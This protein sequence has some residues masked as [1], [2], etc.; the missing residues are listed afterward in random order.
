[1]DGLPT[2]ELYYCRRVIGPVMQYIAVLRGL[3]H[4]RKRSVPLRSKLA[5]QI[6]EM[7]VRL[8]RRTHVNALDK[9]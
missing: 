3:A 5:K 8:W 9:S 4:R 7:L 6:P 2:T 1:M